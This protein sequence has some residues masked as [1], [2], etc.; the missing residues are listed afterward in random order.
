MRELMR[1]Q[2]LSEEDVENREGWKLGEE[3]LKG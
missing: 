1:E 2:G 3:P